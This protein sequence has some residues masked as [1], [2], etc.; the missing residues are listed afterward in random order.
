MSNFLSLSTG[1]YILNFFKE[2]IGTPA[3]LIGL[4]ALIGCLLQRKKFS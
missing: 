3:I 4:F 1:D 2:F